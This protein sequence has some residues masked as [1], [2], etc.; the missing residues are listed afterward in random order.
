MWL[1]AFDVSL[2]SSWIGSDEAKIICWSS[3]RILRGTLESFF[4]FFQFSV[5]FK[6]FIFT[7]DLLFFFHKMQSWNKPNE[8]YKWENWKQQVIWG[9]DFVRTRCW[10][11]FIYC[12]PPLNANPLSAP[13]IN[14]FFRSSIYIQT[15]NISSRILLLKRL[16]TWQSSNR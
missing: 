16:N 5:S 12:P 14:G 2:Y 8:K 10:H 1:L 15:S 7:W 9:Y 3:F 4:K 13:Q 6:L 11:Y